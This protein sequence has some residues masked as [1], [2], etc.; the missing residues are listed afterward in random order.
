MTD[1]TALRL[2]AEMFDD[3][4][5]FRLATA[6]KIR[7][8]GVDAGLTAATLDHYV[9]GEHTMKL[10]LKREFKRTVP[11]SI[12]AWQTEQKGV[13]L[14]LLGRL[15]GRIGDPYMATPMRWD[16]SGKGERVLVTGQPYGRTIS[17]LWSYCGHGDPTR[18]RRAGMSAD[19]AMAMGS[20]Q[21]KMI[22]H[23]LAEACMKSGVRSDENDERYGISKY[24]EVYLE[25]RRQYATKAHS[26]VCVRCGPSGRPAQPESPWSA[27]HQHGAALRK[28]GKELLKD[29]WLAAR[30]A[31]PDTLADGYEVMPIAVPR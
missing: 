2:I 19:D 8:G 26:S 15:L 1:Y 16:G 20:P 14:H 30:E 3:S 10:E 27:G 7:A 4:Q 18:R 12:K 9:A 24:G 29:L 6:N 25:A 28:V 22:V 13:G 23:L 5:K 11:A 17:Q 21:A 31:H